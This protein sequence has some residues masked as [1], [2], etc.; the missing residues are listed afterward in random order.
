MAVAIFFVTALWTTAC[1]VALFLASRRI[2][3]FERERPGSAGMFGDIVPVAYAMLLVSWPRSPCLLVGIGVVAWWML[4][5][6]ELARQGRITLAYV[7]V[8]SCV[9]RWYLSVAMILR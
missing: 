3:D 1:A 7:A 5:T 4:R 2:A 6:P 9:A 8:P